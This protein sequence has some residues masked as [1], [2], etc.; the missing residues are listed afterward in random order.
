[1]WATI[2][3]PCMASTATFDNSFP[4]TLGRAGSPLLL[5]VGSPKDH[6]IRRSLWMN[7]F[8]SGSTQTGLLDHLSA[9]PKLRHQH[10]KIR[11]D[12]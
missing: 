7:Y 3:R 11:E 9:F 2:M 8:R 4:N 1:M 10:A 6:D 5:P 12:L